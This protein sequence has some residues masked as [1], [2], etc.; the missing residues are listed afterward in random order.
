MKE[1]QNH[2][3]RADS[4]HGLPSRERELSKP[5]LSSMRGEQFSNPELAD[6][7]RSGARILSQ[8]KIL[9]WTCENSRKDAEERLKNLVESNRL[10]RNAVGGRATQRGAVDANQSPRTA[11]ICCHHAQ[12]RPEIQIRGQ[13]LGG[14]TARGQGKT[15]ATGFIGQLE[16]DQLDRWDDDGGSILA[17]HMRKR[18]NCSLLLD[19][20]EF[21]WWEFVSYLHVNRP[22]RSE[23]TRNYPNYWRKDGENLFDY[24]RRIQAEIK[25]HFNKEVSAEEAG[26]I[27]QCAGRAFRGKET[28]T[29]RL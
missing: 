8:F 23:K 6:P 4:N 11:S 20:Q 18:D 3:Q 16:P 21:G 14:P 2:E 22:V 19:G 1:D 25:T 5:G 26:Y 7:Y 9:T 17:V 10:Q 13:Y 15:E 28:V 24:T 29:E 12:K 27:V